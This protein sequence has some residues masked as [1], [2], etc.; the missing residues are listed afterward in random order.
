MKV[1]VSAGEVSGDQA[2]ASIL[3]GM[4]AEIPHLELRGLGG[5]ATAAR[6]LEPI[7]P[8]EATAVSGVG[9]VLRS[10]RSLLKA[11]RA[12]F[13]CLESRSAGRPGLALL[14]DYPGINLPLAKRAVSLGIP[15]YY[16][17]PPQ[18][19]IY[20]DPRAKAAKAARSL[21]GAAVHV[22]FPFEQD[23]FAEAAAQVVYGH[24]LSEALAPAPAAPRRGLALCPGSRLPALR[25]NL[26]AWLEALGGA[27]VL[28]EAG[29][30]TVLVPPHLEAAA[31]SLAGG[32]PGVEIVT[33]KGRI[34]RETRFAIAFPGTVTL[35]LALAGVPAAVLAALDPLTL[36][37]GKRLVKGPWLGLPNLLLGREA[38]PEWAGAA[39]GLRP[40]VASRLWKRLC[41][42]PPEGPASSLEASRSLRDLMGPASGAATAAR[43]CL[44]MLGKS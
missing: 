13:D 38:F 5:D 1:F 40:E 22:L 42:V 6:G 23:T 12:A 10:A 44:K 18:A 39:G 3:A 14:V 31:R 17:A 15:T 30:V 41:D 34:L 29:P 19:W 28:A 16:V 36:A 33:D 8:L 7:A 20:K 27:G 26:P 25:R 32:R 9:D 2:L 21:R 4:Q 37:L 35:E 24:F 11:R 43:E